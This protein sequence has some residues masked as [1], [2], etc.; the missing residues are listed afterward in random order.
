MIRYCAGDTCVLFL[1]RHP[2]FCLDATRLYSD[3]QYRFLDQYVSA[4]E[5]AKESSIVDDIIGRRP[6]MV[7][8][9][10]KQQFFTIAL[11]QKGLISEA[12]CRKLGSFLRANYTVKSIGGDKYYI[13]NN[14][15]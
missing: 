9:R 1:P 13:R 7:V 6:A 10:Y 8:F 11:F 5:D 3:W 12:E 15:L 14:K 2:V 4:Q